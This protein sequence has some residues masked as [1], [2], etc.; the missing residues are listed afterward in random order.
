V[1]HAEIGDLVGIFQSGA[2]A[3]TASPLEF[4]SHPEPAEV[5]LHEGRESLANRIVNPVDSERRQGGLRTSRRNN[6]LS[7]LP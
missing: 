6:E 4:L 7:A 2:Y 5:F 1:P 3:K